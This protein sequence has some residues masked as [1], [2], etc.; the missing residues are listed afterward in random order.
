MALVVL[1]VVEQR[2]DPKARD[3]GIIRIIV[4]KLEWEAIHADANQGWD[5]WVDATLVDGSTQYA[6][7]VRKRG[8][9]SV[10]YTTAKRS[11]TVRTPSDEFYK[12]Y[13]TIGLSAKD[14]LPSFVSNSLAREFG[15][16]APHTSVSPVFINDKF[17]GVFRLTETID[18]LR[19]AG[20][21]DSEIRNAFAGA[22][23]RQLP[24][25]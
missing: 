7:K 9:T 18:E 15:L 4:P 20:V 19:E 12:G 13:R 21:T 23:N 1:S 25:K 11:F 10:H 3:G 2:L 8:D 6:V 5:R 17:Y 14:V 24:A 22:I 16:L